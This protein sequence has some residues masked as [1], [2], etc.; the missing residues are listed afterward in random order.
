MWIIKIPEGLQAYFFQTRVSIFPRDWTVNQRESRSRRKSDRGCQTVMGGPSLSESR[1]EHPCDCSGLTGGKVWGNYRQ[2]GDLRGK[3]HGG[4][5]SSPYSCDN[6]T[7][8]FYTLICYPYV[9]QHAGLFCFVVPQWIMKITFFT[10]ILK[11]QLIK[12]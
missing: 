9:H 4:S 3:S 6:A 7:S 10:F 12:I 2:L 1:H 5:L 11:C 8:S